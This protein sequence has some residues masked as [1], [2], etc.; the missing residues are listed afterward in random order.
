MIA[1]DWAG[2]TR[3]GPA[4]CRRD[5]AGRSHGIKPDCEMGT[6]PSCLKTPGALTAVA[7]GLCSME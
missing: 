3:V 2:P 7:P 4:F 6:E 5:P 1:I